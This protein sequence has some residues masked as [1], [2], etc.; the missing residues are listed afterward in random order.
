M[1]KLLIQLHSVA[2]RCISCRLRG[3]GTLILRLDS[4]LRWNDGDRGQ[5]ARFP[6]SLERRMLFGRT[7]YVNNVASGGAMAQ[8]AVVVGCGGRR[9]ALGRR[10]SAA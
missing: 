4:S 2:F 7:T 3:V 5:D 8:W 6:P 9:G 10:R 1:A